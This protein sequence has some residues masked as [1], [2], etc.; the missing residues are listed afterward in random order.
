MSWADTV[1]A[2]ALATLDGRMTTAGPIFTGSP[3][4]WNRNDVWLTRAKQ[5]DD[6]APQSPVRD[7]A[8]PVRDVAAQ[9]D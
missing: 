6:R 8:T 1:R 2:T 4:S 7:P 5:P 3:P 9:N